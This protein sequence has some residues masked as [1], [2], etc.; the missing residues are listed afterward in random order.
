MKYAFTAVC[1]AWLAF[2]APS[3]AQ[4]QGTNA[5]VVELFTSQGC[6]SCPPADAILGKL[7]AD[8]RVIALSLH[9]DYWDYLGWKDKFASP[10]FSARQKAYAR[11]VREKMV[12]TPQ[13]VVQGQD[14][15]I[16]SK[17][18]EVEA[19]IR[20]HLGQIRDIGLT[21]DRRGDRVMIRANP[22]AGGP[23]RVQLVRFS[24]L[25][26]VDIS[27]GENA[28][29]IMTYHNVVKSW[30]LLES[31]SGVDAL[32]IEAQAPGDAPIVVIL[33]A[34]GPAEILAAS[35]LR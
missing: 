28:G 21:L 2:A 14:R 10:A 31:W 16:G 15:M 29:K 23:I 34:E 1:A 11:H 33:Q 35:V 12:F 25:E 19:A 26:T 13:V 22:V 7:S 17:G 20:A 32:S 24:P 4:A 30:E 3:L 6:A 8:A 18:P 5:V 9:V 27:R